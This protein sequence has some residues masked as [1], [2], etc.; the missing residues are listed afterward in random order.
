MKY[1]R[2]KLVVLSAIIPVVWVILMGVLYYRHS[3]RS[4]LENDPKVSISDPSQVILR[5]D[6]KGLYLNQQKLGH[7]HTLLKT[8]SGYGDTIYEIS[9]EVTMNMILGGTRQQ[10]NMVEDTFLDRKMSI[11]SFQFELKTAGAVTKVTG[12]YSRGTLK[13]KNEGLGGSNSNT[14]KMDQPPFSTSAIN[15]FLL[16]EKFPIGKKYKL[17]VFEPNSMGLTTIELE[18]LR[19]ET[20]TLKGKKYETY[21]VMQRFGSYVQQSWIDPKG[22]VIKE[23]VVI[24]GL[25]M[26]SIQEP[27]EIA[28]AIQP[29][30]RPM[31]DLLYQTMVQVTG[32]IPEPRK[33]NELTFKLYGVGTTILPAGGNLHTLLP[34]PDTTANYQLIKVRSLGLLDSK[35]VRKYKPENKLVYLR[36]SQLIQSNDPDIIQQARTITS[37]A[38]DTKKAVELIVL[39]MNKNIDKKLLISIPNAKDVL[40]S[41]EGDCNEHATL[42]AAFARALGIPT[43]ICI[44][45]VYVNDGFFYHA[46]NEVWIGEWIPIDSTFEQTRV[47][48]THIKLLEGDLDQANQIVQYLGKIKIEVVEAKT[49]N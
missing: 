31:E 21:L 42:F 35:P 37:T 26:D 40:H 8:V 1:T 12:N 9:N 27:E 34:N 14:I 17:P 38:T 22:A 10:I 16:Q 47:D 15:L 24:G 36:P 6:W 45:I 32:N 25:T 44:G 46:W 33:T 11:K 19:K 23:S 18:I 2:L 29:G 39:W 3:G 13:V 5:E 48:A 49:G 30:Q 7:S 41:R 43:K 28:I 4:I 20:I